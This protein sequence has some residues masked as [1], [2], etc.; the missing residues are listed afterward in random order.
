MDKKVLFFTVVFAISFLL[1]FS[2]A[3]SEDF[4]RMDFQ[5][6]KAS[7][8]IPSSWRIRDIEEEKGLTI[9]APPTSENV[10]I[11][12]LLIEEGFL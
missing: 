11:L 8:E 4:T 3:L 5:N 1:K 9:I 12:V 2:I 7:I 10:G 6:G